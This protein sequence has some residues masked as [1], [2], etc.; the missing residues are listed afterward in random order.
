MK[1]KILTAV[2][3][4][5]VF[6]MLAAVGV[7]AMSHDHPIYLTANTFSVK[8]GESVYFTAIEN[9]EYGEHI[10]IYMIECEETG[11]I[12]GNKSVFYPTA[13]GEYNFVAYGYDESFEDQ[14]SNTVTIT[15]TG[16]VKK[17]TL[18]TITTQ[19]KS[20]SVTVGQ[21]A[22]FYVKVSNP[23][24]FWLSYNWYHDGVFCDDSGPTLTLKKVDD[25]DS[26]AYYCVVTYSDGSIY[27]SVESNYVNLDVK[28]SVSYPYISKDPVS[29]SVKYGSTATFSVEVANSKGFTLHYQWY[30]GNVTVP[31]G[32]MSTLTLKNVDYF[33]EG[34]YYC[35]VSYYDANVGSDTEISKVAYL[36]VT[37]SASEPTISVQPKS[38]TIHKGDST[39]LS[40][41][42]ENTSGW[43]VY[44]D[45]Y[46]ATN[47]YADGTYVGYGRTLTLNKCT[48]GDEGYYYCVVGFSDQYGNTGLLS[49][50][51]AYVTVTSPSSPTIEPPY[52]IKSP[53][54]LS[55]NIGEKATFKIE[56]ANP[57]NAYTF[58]YQWYRNNT[59]ISGATSLT[60]SF[61]PTAAN[62]GDLYACEVTYNGKRAG[63]I[64]SSA[65]KLSVSGVNA[66]KIT[67]SPVNVSVPKGG[68]LSLTATA[69]TS[70]ASLSY[71][72]YRSD[73]NTVSSAEILTGATSRTYSGKAPSADGVYYYYCYVTA[74]SGTMAVSDYAVATVTV[75]TGI[76]AAKGSMSNFVNTRAYTKGHFK[77]VDE[78]EWYGADNNGVIKRAFELGLMNGTGDGTVFSPESTFDLSQVITVAARLHA[79][80]TN[81]KDTIQQGTGANW[82]APYVDYAVENAIINSNDFAEYDIPATRAQMAYIFSNA[83]P[84]GQLNAIRVVRGI[85]D[86][87][88][89][90]PYYASI[91]KLYAAGI[92]SGDENHNYF[93][94]SYITRAE[95]SAIIARV[96]LPTIRN[97]ANID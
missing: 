23:D 13:P 71:Q 55:V 96:A 61:Y 85:P 16:S 37:G 44:Y 87:T 59:R 90:T 30:H 88:E 74:T 43:D 78:T 29:R 32:T 60:Y 26:G 51:R 68:A 8:V 42:L 75:G 38:K 28:G 5:C 15:V 22:T 46:Y 62:N 35:E 19:P 94:S 92:V 54:N 21:T 65:A 66:P 83:L 53:S 31:G 45:W 52:F 49:S 67:M 95:A 76:N 97:T 81:G 93:P 14:S 41:T 58:S 56:L 33:D 86:C 36:E 72:W 80:Y 69:S 64:L 3:I 39:T 10:E 6:A 79:I 63:S 40:I 27:D 48:Y 2:L 77:D 50:S 24:D 11:E 57:S 20:T 70:G 17:K 25:F 1:K 18:P 34:E 7:A 73:K 89:K 84:T 12:L 82:Y 9:P 47:T 4:A 91:M